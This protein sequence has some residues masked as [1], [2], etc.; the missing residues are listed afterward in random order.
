M[1]R[2]IRSS[3]SGKRIN[4]SVILAAALGLAGF[5]AFAD[6]VSAALLAGAGLVAGLALF[7][8][9]R[10]TAVGSAL[11]VHNPTSVTTMPW[12]Q[13]KGATVAFYLPTRA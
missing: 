3:H 5:A 12:V 9:P 13:L 4:A 7:A 6:I 1:D 8:L 2:T 11:V 10:L